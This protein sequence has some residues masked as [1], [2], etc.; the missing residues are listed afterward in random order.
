M[1]QDVDHREASRVCYVKV[2]TFAQLE[3]SKICV[4][5]TTCLRIVMLTVYHDF[6]VS[7]YVM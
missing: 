7:V 1:L 5:T 4:L 2:V 6:K 3:E